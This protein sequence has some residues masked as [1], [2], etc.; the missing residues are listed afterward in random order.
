M[1]V[2]EFALAVVVKRDAELVRTHK[3][4]KAQFDTI[5]RRRGTG[6]KADTEQGRGPQENFFH[7]EIP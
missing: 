4:T 2:A 1:V 6:Q 5:G 3:A 7:L